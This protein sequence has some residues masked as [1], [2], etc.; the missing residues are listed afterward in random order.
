MTTETL[1]TVLNETPDA[2]FLK[3]LAGRYVYVNVAAARFLQLC[4][5]DIMGKR[6]AELYPAETAEAFVAA[7]RHVLESGRT[8]QF[9]SVA[10]SHTGEEQVYVVTKGVYRDA[11]GQPAGVYGISHQAAERRS[12][13][14]ASSRFAEM[15]R[16][17]DAALEAD[18]LKSQFLANMSH[19][20]RT[21]MNGILG[22]TALALDTELS[23]FQRS[24]LTTVQASATRLLALINDILDLSKIESAGLSVRVEPF[25]LREFA[26]Q[27]TALL[28]ADA[29][30]KGLDFQLAIDANVPDWLAGDQGRLGQVLTNLVANAIK[31]TDRGVVRLQVDGVSQTDDDI[32]LHVRVSDSGIGIA[33]ADLELIFESF[34][35]VD[36]SATRSRGGT[37]LGLAITR[38]IVD[39]MGGRLTVESVPER[40][41]TFHVELTLRRAVPV[42]P[43][44]TTAATD[45]PV[46][47]RRVLVA[48]DNVV[49]QRVTAGML[50]ARGHHV[51]IVNDGREALD[52]LQRETFDV[53]LMDVQMPVMDGLSACAAIR[54]RERANGASQRIVAMTAHAMSGDRQRCLDAGM[55]GY[56]SKPINRRDLFAAVELDIQTPLDCARRAG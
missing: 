35:Q 2:V 16:A 19:E 40:G 43:A 14:D 30:A 48:E 5:R 47:P 1:L 20:I 33:A 51:V 37:G 42:T 8:C 23:D 26:A 21:P 6:D 7:D 13:S 3:D 22:M 27:T 49:N 12:D 32:R 54:E 4:P 56:L 17:R 41:S 34:R 45:A 11:T 55:D 25:S 36:G 9:E 24:C 29:R 10:R 15:Q 44:A 38:S 52:T 31:F 28:A 46:R 50:A 39:A 18:R 53:V